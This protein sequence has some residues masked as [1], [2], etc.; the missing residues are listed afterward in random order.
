M[1]IAVVYRWASI[2]V[3]EKIGGKGKWGIGFNLQDRVYDIEL[4]PHRIL[5]IDEL[6]ERYGSTAAFMV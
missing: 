4:Y 5:T 2:F 6:Q 3:S 1:G